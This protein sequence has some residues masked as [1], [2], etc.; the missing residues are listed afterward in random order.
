MTSPSIIAFNTYVLRRRCYSYRYFGNGNK[1]VLR[2]RFEVKGGLTA[3]EIMADNICKSNPLLE[4][5]RD[6]R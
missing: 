6:N 3:V 1:R 4:R 5:V 2:H